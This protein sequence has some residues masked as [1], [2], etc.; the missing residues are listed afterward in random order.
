M[1]QGSLPRRGPS[2][3]RIDVARPF[4]KWAGGKRQLIR[5]LCRFVPGQFGTYHEPFVGGGALFFHL[6]PKRAVLSDSNARLVRTYQGIQNSVDEVIALLRSYPHDKSFFLKLRALPIDDQSDAELAAWFIFLNK[7]GFNGL[8]RVNRKNIFNVPFGDNAHTR[9]LDEDNLRA[10]S[11][12]LMGRT[13]SIAKG[14]SLW[15][16]NEQKVG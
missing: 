14:I 13:T 1:A 4:L 9:V 15:L 2:A 7:T 16:W 5:E 10:C 11:A 6:K 12:A 8:Y 3:D